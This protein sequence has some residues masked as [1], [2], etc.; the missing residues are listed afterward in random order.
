MDSYSPIISFFITPYC[1]GLGSPRQTLTRTWIELVYV[2]QDLGGV[3]EAE[4]RE[5]N[6]KKGCIM[7]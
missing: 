2:G 4:R 5:R 3:R 1:L 7:G 6:A